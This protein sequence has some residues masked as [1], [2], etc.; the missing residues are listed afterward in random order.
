MK[1]LVLATILPLLSAAAHGEAA[2]SEER[3]FAA[4]PG[5]GVRTQ[6]I[7]GQVIYSE[8]RAVAV[9]GA[10]LLEDHVVFSPTRKIVIKQGSFLRESGD[11]GESRH[12]YNLEESLG[13]HPT[14]AAC[15]RDANDDGQFD[16]LSYP[17]RQDSYKMLGGSGPKY[18]EDIEPD[19]SMT[20]RCELRFEGTHD[21]GVRLNYSEFTGSRSKPDVDDDL[22]FKLQP[23][24]AEI[25]FRGARVRIFSASNEV[26]DYEVLSG[27]DD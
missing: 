6:R 1:L 2:P 18:K 23:G 16:Q 10:R 15:F 12:C 24:A 26:I 22:T 17:A 3:V 25:V 5:I 14:E 9:V 27:L 20:S 21:E 4:K 19:L 13:I 11:G 7:R 8:F